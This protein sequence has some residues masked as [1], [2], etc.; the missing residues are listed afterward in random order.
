[1]I[2]NLGTT[3]VYLGHEPVPTSTNGYYLD[4]NGGYLS[5]TWDEDGE[6]VGYPLYAVAE[7]LTPTIF[8]AAVVAG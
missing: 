3:A 8:I 6:L 2:F 1:I 4:K 5:M 7:S